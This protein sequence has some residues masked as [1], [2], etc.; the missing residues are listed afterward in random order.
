VRH[1][2]N[3]RQRFAPE[4]KRRNPLEIVGAAN[5]AGRMAL[6]GQPGV[7]RIH[8]FSV[9]LDADQLLAAEF[10]GDGQPPGAGVD[11]VLDQLFDDGGRTFNHLARG[12]LVGKIRRQPVNLRHAVRSTSSGG[13]HRASR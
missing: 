12:D 1:R 5:L 3:A 6:D 2:G 9:V 7:L 4:P 13:T 11:R 8:P 10:D